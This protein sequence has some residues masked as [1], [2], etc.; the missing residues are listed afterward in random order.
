MSEQLEKKRENIY[1]NNFEIVLPQYC[2]PQNEIIHWTCENHLQSE[3]STD[4]DLPRFFNR[5]AVQPKQISKRYFECPDILNLEMGQAQIYNVSAEKS[6]GADIN[7]RTHFFSEKALKV[8]KSLYAEKN[9]KPDHIV[10]V[11]C[12]GYA[13]PSAAQRIVIEPFWQDTT[14]ITHAY[15]MG[16]YAALPAIRIAQGLVAFEKD[17]NI[18]FKVDVVHTEM[19]GLHMNPA[20]HSPEQIV[21]QSLFADGHIKYSATAKPADFGFNL[22]V[23]AIHEKV[24]P[25]TTEDMSWVPAAWGMKMTLSREVP[26][27]IKSEIK[28]FLQE[29]IAKTDL[30]LP[31]VMKAVFA[32]HP[33][34][35]KIIDAVQEILE[36]SDSQ[37]AQSKKVLFERGNMSSATLPHV[38]AEILSGPIARG[39]KIISFA[40]GPGLTLFGSVFEVC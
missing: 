6:Y 33:G 32:V 17:N 27:K 25:Q 38:W 24:I 22:K 29:L 13:S 23:L 8:F 2:L 3:T 1:L 7:Q 39:T 31:Q 15:H 30:L 21:V 19:C 10:H 35:P 5:Y 34:G 28:V 9:K 16:C 4:L 26:Q 37:T 18:D 40:F 20:D 12:T 36:L 14:A 11:T